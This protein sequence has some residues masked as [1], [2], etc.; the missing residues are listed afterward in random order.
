MQQVICHLYVKVLLCSGCAV[1]S[2]HMGCEYL[3]FCLFREAVSSS[4]THPLVWD[5]EPPGDRKGTLTALA[6]AFPTGQT[7]G[8]GTK[9][10]RL[11]LI[12]PSSRSLARRVHSAPCTCALERLHG[13]GGGWTD[14]EAARRLG[15]TSQG[16]RCRGGE[17]EGCLG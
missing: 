6:T 10:L 8:S 4:A 11:P 13:D 14:V 16:R 2:I 12:M 17:D 1:V 15:W 5:G 9:S 7:K 3:W